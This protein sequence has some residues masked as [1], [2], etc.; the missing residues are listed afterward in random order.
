MPAESALTFEIGGPSFP[1]TVGAVDSAVTI[2]D[3][4]LHE[5]CIDSPLAGRAE[6]NSAG[7]NLG[8]YRVDDL[9]RLPGSEALFPSGRTFV[10][11]LRNSSFHSHRYV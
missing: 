5:P 10:V 6:N 3:L 11:D 1:W 4:K 2:L 7:R 8:V 9:V